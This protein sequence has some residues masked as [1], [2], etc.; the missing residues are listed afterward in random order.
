SGR[1]SV[2]DNNNVCEV[3]MKKNQSFVLEPKYTARYALDKGVDTDDLDQWSTE[4][5]D[6]LSAYA[7]AGQGYTQSPYQ[8]GASD[9]NYYGQYYDV[10][11]YGNVWQPNNVGMTWDPFGNGYWSY[12]PGFGYTWVSSYPWG[13]MPYR[14][15]QWIFINNRGWCWAPGGWNRWYSRPR[16]SHAPPG[17]HAPIPPAAR[18]IVNGAPGE[19]NRQPSRGGDGGR[20]SG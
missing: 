13:W 3:D 14:Y 6:A 10:P 2:R 5:D 19:I 11:G 4:R 15:G 12:A 8:Y 9:L 16:W 20:N 18:R 1:V 7:S 17:F